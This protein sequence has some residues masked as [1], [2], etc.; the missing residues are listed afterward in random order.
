MP[1]HDWRR[2]NAGTFYHF[3]TTWITHTSDRLNDGLLPA[4]YYA[5]A[6]QHAGKMIADVLTLQVRDA[7]PLEAA[8][9]GGPIAVADAP[10]RTSRKMVA[11]PDAVYREA[12]RTLTVRHTSDHHV[13]AMLEIVSRANKDRES[14][15]SEFVEKVWAALRDGVHLLVL[16]LF[17]SGKYDPGGMHNMIWSHYD[18]IDYEPPAEKPLTAVAYAAYRLPEAYVEPLAVGDLLPDMPLFLHPDWYLNVPL[19]NTY[20][21]AYRGVPAYW[22]GVVEGTNEGEQN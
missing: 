8:G 1:I 6:E 19:E 15:V 18:A 2:V 16:D 3:H 10:P 4:G 13:V 20:Q 9:G 14:S 17:P 12:R 5:M 11:S 22:R 7:P 21:T